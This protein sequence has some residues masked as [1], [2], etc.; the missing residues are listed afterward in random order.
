MQYNYTLDNDTSFTVIFNLKQ[1][2]QQIEKLLNEA[3]SLK[4][5]SAVSHWATESDTLHNAI[6]TLENQRKAQYGKVMVIQ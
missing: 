5:D 4:I 6:K 1:R 3:I 2:Q